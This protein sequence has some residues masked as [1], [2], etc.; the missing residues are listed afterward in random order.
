MSG[1]KVD[2]RFRNLQLDKADDFLCHL[3]NTP[4]VPTHRR[5]DVLPS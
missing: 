5:T 2:E 1:Y 3:I 4:W